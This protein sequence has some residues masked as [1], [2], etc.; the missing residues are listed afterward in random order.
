MP[1]RFPPTPDPGQQASWPGGAPRT[2]LTASIL[3]AMV[4]LA[5][6]VVVLAVAAGRPGAIAAA[7]L[8]AGASLA[9]AVLVAAMAARKIASETIVQAQAA[10]T[11]NRVK[12]EF[13]TLLSHELRN[14]LGAIAAAVDVLDSPQTQAET[15]AEAR[16]IIARQTRNLS[17]MLNDVLEVS[18]LLAGKSALERQPLDLCALVQRVRQ[19][20]APTGAAAGHRLACR[21]ESAWT[22]GDAVRLEQVVANLLAYAYR[23]A[24]PGGEIELS[25]RREGD[26]A[27]MQVQVQ[28]CGEDTT[29]NLGIGLALAQ[30]LVEL[31]GGTV[32]VDHRPEGISLTMR[33][34]AVQPVAGP[35]RDSLPVER[36]RKVLVVEANEDVVAALRTDLELDGHT[37]STAADGQEGL[38][39]LLSQRPEVSI[40]GI[41]L[42]GMGGYALA[43]QARAAG[44]AGRMIALSGEDHEQ[45]VAGALVAG[46]DA[47]LT[48][49]LDQARLRASIAG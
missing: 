43:R 25:V 28:D 20:M 39:R 40:V 8:A 16:A 33:L 37:V 23:C 15:A 38:R 47:C 36:R 42:P 1:S 48:G 30:R 2:W 45:D 49:P 3:L 41:G 9:L 44:Y 18:R 46:F 19:T 10:A 21:L 12:D 14:P 32:D 13:F 7:L 5:A 27:L 35:E 29:G 24:P 34:Q 26:I 31:H 6:M 22:D 4:P 17:H 11:A